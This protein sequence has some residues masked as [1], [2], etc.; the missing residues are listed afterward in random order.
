[1]D[2]IILVVDE[3]KVLVPVAWIPRWTAL[4]D[5]I[6]ATINTEIVDYD[7]IEPI[8]WTGS[9]HD[10]VQEWVHLNIMMDDQKRGGCVYKLSRC[11]K[12]VQYMNPS[13]T[14]Y[15][16]YAHIDYNMNKSDR[17]MLYEQLGLSIRKAGIRYNYTTK[18][19]EGIHNH[20]LLYKDPVYGW[21]GID[22]NTRPFSSLPD[23]V[24]EMVMDADLNV[25][26]GIMHSAWVAHNNEKATEI[27]W[28]CV[29]WDDIVDFG[30]DN[31]NLTNVAVEGKITTS[32]RAFARDADAKQMKQWNLNRLKEVPFI[33]GCLGIPTFLCRRQCV[34][35]VASKILISSFAYDF[36]GLVECY[37]ASIKTRVE[38]HRY[39]LDKV[40]I[41]GLFIAVVGPAV[42][43]EPRVMQPFG[44]KRML[45]ATSAIITRTNNT[46]SLVDT[47][48]L[49]NKVIWNRGKDTVPE[50]DEYSTIC[51][52]M[53]EALGKNYLQFFIDVVV[54]H[55]EV[56]MQQKL[57]RQILNNMIKFTSV[58]LDILDNKEKVYKYKCP[59]PHKFVTQETDYTEE[60]RQLSDLYLRRKKRMTPNPL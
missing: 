2:T 41:S 24:Q 7:K 11:W 25:L 50:V 47:I 34:E 60:D 3:K 18:S 33:K 55:A 4:S 8:I 31:P 28:H 30:Y 9:S 27:L 5:M 38:R 35:D 36:W 21:K 43:V 13:N 59:V 58:A 32:I 22:K 15:L 57:S 45:L 1:M 54:A 51:V 16:N 56:S 37:L 46:Q 40:D 14:D 53:I 44:T 26:T 6:E 19:K 39:Q 17:R 10:D 48:N 23:C 12:T 20:L 52:Q 42:S 29:K 49:T